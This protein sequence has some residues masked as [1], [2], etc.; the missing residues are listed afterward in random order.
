MAGPPYLTDDPVP[1]DERHF[2][3]YAFAAGLHNR[4]GSSSDLGI[5]FNYG[6]ARDLQLTVVLPMAF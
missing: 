6:G 2:E 3:I 1:T 5:D 4:S